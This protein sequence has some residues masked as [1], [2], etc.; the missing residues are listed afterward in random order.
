MRDVH[1]SFGIFTL[2]RNGIYPMLHCIITWGRPATPTSR[3]TRVCVWTL[4]MS[5]RTADSQFSFHLPSLTYIDAKWEEP[6]L[7]TPTAPVQ[8]S[9]TAKLSGWLVRR[10]QAIV[11]WRRDQQA[12]AELASM[13]DH[14]L[15]DIGISRS[16]LSRAFG[17]AYNQDLVRRG[18]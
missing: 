14:E 8:P 15:M 2:Y 6:N 7:R 16:D 12:A 18:T 13:S 9:L 10:L 4:A 17:P 3:S 5:D 11:A 1:G